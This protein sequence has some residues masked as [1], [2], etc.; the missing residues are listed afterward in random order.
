MKV[1]VIGAGVMGSMHVRA[2]RNHRDVDVVQVV[3]TDVERAK[4]LAAFADAEAGSCVEDVPPDIDAVV[5]A[6]STL[7]HHD[8]VRRLLDRDRPPA[9]LIEK[10]LAATYEQATDLV[11]R[12]SG[13]SDRI[14]VGHVERFNP[15]V[16][17][18][19][20]WRDVAPAHVEMR[21]VGPAASRVDVDVVRDLMIH[22]LDILCALLGNDF[23]RVSAVVRGDDARGVDLAVAALHSRQGVTASVTA[24]RIS[25]LK[26]RTLSLAC[27]DVQIVADLIRQQVTIHRTSHQEF[28]DEGGVRYRQSGMVEIPYLR[29]GEP[30]MLEHA[31]FVDVVRGCATPRISIQDGADVL[32]LCDRVLKAGRWTDSR[33]P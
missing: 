20:R 9:M 14:L 15:A 4:T 3:D 1:A 23:D 2:L 13:M 6:C 19:L 21:R 32:A 24:S 27:G 28:S 31:H 7:Q 8:V 16:E 29:H 5:V 25:Q 18:V 26:E 30:L 22:D 17:E 11:R 10:P 12:A 33:R